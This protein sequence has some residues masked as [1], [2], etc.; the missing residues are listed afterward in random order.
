ME[1]IRIEVAKFAKNCN[2]ALI[3]TTLAGGEKHGYQIAVEIEERSGGVF[4]F[5]H[6]TLY[7]ILHKLEQ[8]GLIAGD[9]RQEGPKRQRKYYRLTGEGAAYLDAQAAALRQFTGALS[10]FLGK[11]GT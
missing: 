8:E 6:G 3:L 4:V 2:E 10:G 9:W 5:K 1:P 7:P 11:E